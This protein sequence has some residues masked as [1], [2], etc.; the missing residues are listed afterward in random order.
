M[1]S[2]PATRPG[3][4]S[5]GDA[6]NVAARLEQA[7][8]ANEILLGPETYRLVRDAVEVEPLEPLELKGKAEPVA[9]YRLESPIGAAALAEERS[10]LIGR[11]AELERLDAVM[12]AAPMIGRAR[13]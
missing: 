10:A 1:R 3:R 2:S 11:D 5:Y 7:A 12:D 13:S 9:T 8:P 4:R 6:I